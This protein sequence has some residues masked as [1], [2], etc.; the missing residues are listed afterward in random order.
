MIQSVLPNPDGP[1]AC[2][3]LSS[4][5]EAAIIALMAVHEIFTDG[6]YKRLCGAFQFI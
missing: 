5:I 2:L 3:M 4:A 1:L 6:H